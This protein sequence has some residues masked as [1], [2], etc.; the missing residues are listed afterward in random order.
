MHQKTV[1]KDNHK[2]VVNEDASATELYDLGAD[3]RQMRNLAGLSEHNAVK[4]DLLADLAR[5]TEED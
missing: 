2:L 4:S 3:P 5:V 1:V